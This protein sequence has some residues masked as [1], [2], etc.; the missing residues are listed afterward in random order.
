MT[1]ADRRR[2]LSELK[3]IIARVQ[4][5]GLS[6]SIEL[7]ETAAIIAV[8]ENL[9][10][11]QPGKGTSS[12][13]FR[14]LRGIQDKTNTTA[15]RYMP[16]A[17]REGCALCCNIF[18]SASAPEVFSI[19]DYI[20]T[21]ADDLTAELNRFGP[22]EALT[23]GL[24][25]NARAE[26][27]IDCPLLVN[28][29]CS[30]YPARP[31]ACRG[32]F[33]LDFADCEAADRGEDKDIRKPMMAIMGRASVLQALWS[34]LYKRGLRLPS[35]ELGHALN[36]A[37]DNTEAEA[38]WYRGEDVFK[39]VALDTDGERERQQLGSMGELFWEIL[40]D[41]A[42]GEVPQD[43]PMTSKLASWCFA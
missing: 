17:C 12:R 21:T 4:A 26:A 7:V 23:R 16:V 31:L 14:Q 13:V 27:H 35:Y 41:V 3:R 11:D 6:D 9:L 18:V 20:R 43:S 2:R 39:D 29:K 24:G 19:A 34:V 5:R 25:I 1:R 36:I 22:L 30:I 28:S 10:G 32:H 37:L 33:S 8:I 40:W 15:V 42:H 38:A